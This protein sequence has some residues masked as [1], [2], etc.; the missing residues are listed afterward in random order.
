MDNVIQCD[1][2]AHIRL[3]ERQD[4]ATLRCPKCRALISSPVLTPSAGPADS[5][6]VG[7]ICP[8]CQTT[9]GV[10]EPTLPCPDCRQVHHQECWSE[11]GGCATYGCKQSPSIS[12]DATAANQTP[13]SAWGD[14]K[15][16]PACGERIRSIAVKCRYCGTDFGTVDP[17]SAAD[18]R[19]RL[20]TG[21]AAKSM[22]TGVVAL[23]AFSVIGLLAPLMAII[24][25]VWVLPKRKE[26]LKA[27]PVYLVLGYTSVALSVLYSILMLAFAMF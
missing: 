23:F 22:R 4:A 21:D 8:T 16:C 25:L 19:A 17:L 18:L 7:G 6:G 14:T 9:I 11:L 24:S 2:G 20:A 3:P 1:C 27:G 26:L 12:K 10:G 5:E 15:P 13:L